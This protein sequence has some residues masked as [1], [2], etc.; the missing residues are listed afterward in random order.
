MKLVIKM[1]EKHFNSIME[2]LPTYRYHT[3]REVEYG[4]LMTAEIL[5]DKEEQVLLLDRSK[6]PAILY[7][8]VNDF[9]ILADQI[10]KLEGAIRI[11]FV[12]YEFERELSMLGFC[13]WAEYVDFF[14]DDLSATAKSFGAIPD[15]QYLQPNECEEASRL[16]KDLALSTRGFT[17]ETSQWFSQWIKE[18]HVIVVREDNQM[19]GF[20]CVA[21][22]A[23]GTRL[24][25][26]EIGVSPI[27]QRK[28]YAKT[29]MAQ[30]I[31]FGVRKGAQKGFLAADA[32]NQGAITL[33][34][35]FGFVQA[36]VRGELQMIRK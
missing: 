18:N 7:F 21:I 15:V 10:K 17:G 25:I 12:P 22:Y 8:A 29:M 27:H 34:K 20:C 31:A 6:T 23:N 19:T 35:N 28:G 26:R 36:D 3:I 11:H 2:K 4:D 1:T 14:N 5:C 13:Q 24:W 33:Y 32:L 9:A 30:A 16:S